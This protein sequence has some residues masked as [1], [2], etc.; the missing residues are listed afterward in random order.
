MMLEQRDSHEV[1]MNKTI[2][3]VEFKI[4]F[5]QNYMS[6]VYLGTVLLKKRSVVPEIQ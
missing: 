5:T 4:L 1:T 2:A 6:G 3:V